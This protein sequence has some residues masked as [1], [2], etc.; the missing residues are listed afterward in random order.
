MAQYLGDSSHPVEQALGNTGPYI[1][2]VLNPMKRSQVPALQHLPL[3]SSQGF[4]DP[5]QSSLVK[6]STVPPSEILFGPSLFL[7]VPPQLV[8]QNL[9]KR[10]P[11]MLYQAPPRITANIY[12]TLLLATSSGM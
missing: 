10:A 8:S 9:A 11:F 4:N 1:G 2:L 12:K 6:S 7:G 3:K 5:I